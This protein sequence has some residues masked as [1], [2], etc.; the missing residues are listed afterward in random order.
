MTGSFTGVPKYNVDTCER[1]VIINYAEQAS[2]IW[3]ITHALLVFAVQANVSRLAW[4]RPATTTTV[5][6]IRQCELCYID[7]T[8]TQNIPRQ[9]LQLLLQ[10]SGVYHARDSQTNTRQSLSNACVS[11]HMTA[12]HFA[13][14]PTTSR[15]TCYLLALHVAE[16]Y[17]HAE[18]IRSF[19]T[20]P[21]HVPLVQSLGGINR[22][23]IP[24]P[25][26]PSEYVQ[27][28]EKLRPYR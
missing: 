27:I 26:S 18:R 1:P 20:S 23:L 22:R 17:P 11:G 4:I 13:G 25:R 19:I 12:Y 16:I 2:Q 24:C 21:G 15:R 8:I 9:S 14:K 28:F 6:N 3:Y 5:T 7:V 10:F